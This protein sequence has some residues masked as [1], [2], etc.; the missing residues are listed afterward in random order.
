VVMDNSYV[1][2]DNITQEALHAWRVLACK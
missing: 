1:P 2:K